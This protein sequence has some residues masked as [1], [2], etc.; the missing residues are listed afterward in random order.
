M[1]MVVMRAH[2]TV[3]PNLIAWEL[4]AFQKKIKKNIVI[5]VIENR[6]IVIKIFEIL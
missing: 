4:N 2:L 3:Q 1:F 5:V 6:I